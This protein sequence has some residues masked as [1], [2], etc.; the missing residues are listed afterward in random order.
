[1]QTLVKSNDL[2]L[3]GY[4]EALLRGADIDH[5]VLDTNMSVLEGSVGAIPRRV[6]VHAQDINRARVILHD[7]GLAHEFADDHE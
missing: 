4:V 3:I 5:V 7:V 6:V 2:V 1:M